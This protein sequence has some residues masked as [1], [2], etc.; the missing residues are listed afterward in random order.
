M[1]KHNFRPHK[2]LGQ[3][4]LVDEKVLEKIARTGEIKKDDLVIEIGPGLGFLTHKLADLAGKI[5]AVEIDRKLVAIL[6]EVLVAYR[7]IEII[8]A[9]FLDI[10]FQELAKGPAEKVKVIANLPYYIT[11]PVLMQLI[12]KRNLWDRL[13]LMTQLEVAERMT[14]LPGTRIRGALSVA[15]QHYTEP[16]IM[17]EVPGS[18]FVPPTKVMSAVVKLTGKQATGKVRDEKLFFSVVRAAFE[19]RRKM[20]HNTLGANLGVPKE[21]LMS[22]FRKSGIDSSRRAET[23]TLDEFAI[24]SNNIRELTCK[25]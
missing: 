22:A 15:V 16:E 10:E 2:R 21:I 7:N 24:L 14:A 18:S 20:L 1:E 17:F 13:V 11:T 25:N 6:K 8:R 19:Q 9:D 12:P 4:F 3:N 5:I 23:L